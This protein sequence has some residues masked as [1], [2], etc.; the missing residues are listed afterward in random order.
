MKNNMDNPL[1][2]R[3]TGPNKAMIG[4]VVTFEAEVV[5]GVVPIDYKWSIGSL[6]TDHKNKGER[7]S[8]MYEPLWHF[9]SVIKVNVKDNISNED[10]VMIRFKVVEKHVE[11]YFKKCYFCDKEVVDRNNFEES[12]EYFKRY[13]Q[14]QLYIA[15]K[16]GDKIVCKNCKG[17]IW[18]LAQD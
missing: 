10:S 12:R 14:L 3:I 7:D 9:D 5:G 13:H 6:T 8:L 16:I 1:M 15:G 18:E 17:D 11:G 2:V 4:D